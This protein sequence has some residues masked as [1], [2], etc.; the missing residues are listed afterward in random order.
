MSSFGHLQQVD[1]LLYNVDQNI[2]IIFYIRYL[3]DNN[4][5]K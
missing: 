1:K 5:L 4:N 3:I 2:K